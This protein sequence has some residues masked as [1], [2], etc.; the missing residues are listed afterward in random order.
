MRAYILTQ[1]NLLT[2]LETLELDPF[3]LFQVSLDELE[4]K[5]GLNFSALDD[6]ETFSPDSEVEALG[7]DAREIKGREQVIV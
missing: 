6:F 3:K 1:N 7:V 5:T 4:N 2:D